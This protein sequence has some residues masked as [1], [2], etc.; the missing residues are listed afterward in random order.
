MDTSTLKIILQ[1]FHYLLFAY[2]FS[3]VLSYVILSVISGKE[4][5]EYLKKNSF[6]NY[7]DILSST[8][9]PSIT[10]IAPAYNESLNVVE[11]VRSLLS[12]H[13]VNYDVLI[14]NDGSK[15][16]SLEKLIEAYDLEKIDY[17]INEK[18][19]TKPLRSGIYKSKNPAF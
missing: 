17:I 4:T 9:S 5:I 7:R 11:N 12:N 3:A 13:Y 6:V 19:K 15:D 1:I 10:I 18:I 16:D 2:A 8:M 14:I